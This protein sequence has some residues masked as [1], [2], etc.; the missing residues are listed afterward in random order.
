MDV[1]KVVDRVVASFI[2][3]KHERDIKKLQ[4]LIAAINAVR[5]TLD[6]S[7]PTSR[8]SSRACLRL[9]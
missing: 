5:N 9:V 4:P 3:T 1:A 7:S 8:F 2:G 6:S